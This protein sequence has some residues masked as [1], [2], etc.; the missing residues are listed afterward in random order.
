[1]TLRHAAPIA[2]LALSMLAAGCARH[3]HPHDA[4]APAA[5]AAASPE[6]LQAVLASADA[7]DGTT[8]HVVEKCAGCSL[9][10]PGSKDHAVEAHGYSLHF[11]SESCKT[12]SAAK[13]DDVI[14]SLK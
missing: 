7:K 2:V 1:M 5:A 9:A 10:M 14:A 12:R 4:P 3:E 11:C 13:I 6:A 8:D